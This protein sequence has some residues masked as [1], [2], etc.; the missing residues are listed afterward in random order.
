MHFLY[1]AKSEIRFVL[2][3]E[4]DVRRN[5]AEQNIGFNQHN[6]SNVR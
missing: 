5:E 3:I 1:R 6:K 4:A 2:Q